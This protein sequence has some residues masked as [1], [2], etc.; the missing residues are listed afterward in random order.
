[1]KNPRAVGIWLVC[2]LSLPALA[3]TT[4]TAYMCDFESLKPGH[5]TE[6]IEV[7]EINRETQR[8][9]LRDELAPPRDVA[10]LTSP[11][12]ITFIENEESGRLVFTT[13]FAS[14]P[15]D[16]TLDAV[17]SRHLTVMTGM[18]QPSQRVGSCRAESN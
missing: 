18:P 8:A 10:V 3:S 13:I 4:P 11:A 16:P 5:A 17:Q 1:M 2:A 9:V 14:P 12:A 6:R 7:H 15:D